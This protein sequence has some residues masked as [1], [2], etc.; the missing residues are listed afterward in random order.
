VTKQLQLIAS[1]VGDFSM[2]RLGIAVVVT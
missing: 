2:T 1:E